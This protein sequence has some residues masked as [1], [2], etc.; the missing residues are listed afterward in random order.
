[1]SEPCKLIGESTS[2][3]KKAIG[4]GLGA[5]IGGGKFGGGTKEDDEIW[6]GNERI[7]GIPL[8]LQGLQK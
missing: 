1:M 2:F 5:K 7:L 8:S 4:G 6:N 3:V